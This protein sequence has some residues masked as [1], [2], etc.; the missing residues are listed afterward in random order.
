M[1][2]LGRVEAT[3]RGW[4]SWPRLWWD[5]VRAVLEDGEGRVQ[6]YPGRYPSARSFWDGTRRVK[7]DSKSVDRWLSLRKAS[8]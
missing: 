4:L 8:T 3:L 1:H 2:T 6:R 7:A 5:V